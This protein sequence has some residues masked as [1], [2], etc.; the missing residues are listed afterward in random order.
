M[1]A[2]AGQTAQA[3]GAAADAA[4]QQQAQPTP[5]GAQTQA[6][7]PWQGADAWGGFSGTAAGAGAEQADSQPRL[8]Q[9]FGI[10]MLEFLFIK[11][12]NY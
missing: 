4:E 12:N 8:P 9:A 10:A 11:F 3:A 7:E 5:P 1:A 2:A 6:G